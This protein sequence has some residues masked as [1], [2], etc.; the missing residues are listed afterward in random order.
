MYARKIGITQPITGPIAASSSLRHGS[1]T[2]MLNPTQTSVK[3]ERDQRTARSAGARKP[4]LHAAQSHPTLRPA[5]A[6][7][8]RQEHP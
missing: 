3:V 2:Q 8:P 7:A 4:E 1:D 5:A 6:D